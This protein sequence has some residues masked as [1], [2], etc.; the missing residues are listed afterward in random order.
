MQPHLFPLDG[1]DHLD[2]QVV[3]GLHLSRLHGQLALQQQ[4]G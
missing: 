4:G 3:N 1:L 2:T